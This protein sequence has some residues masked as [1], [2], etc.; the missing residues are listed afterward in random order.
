MLWQGD[1]RLVFASC[2]GTFNPC[3]RAHATNKKES[4]EGALLDGD[5]LVLV[6]TGNIQV[7]IPVT[8]RA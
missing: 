8:I 3:D 7:P 5:G 1:S 2:K 4:P 6:V